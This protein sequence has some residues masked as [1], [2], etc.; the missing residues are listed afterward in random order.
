MESKTPGRLPAIR[1]N[2]AGQV[3][4]V[5]RPPSYFLNAT[6]RPVQ[7]GFVALTGVPLTVS[8]S[9]EF[10]KLAYSS[11]KLHLDPDS[12]EVSKRSVTQQ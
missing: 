12:V 5:I 6:Y 9:V 1:S 8:S 3:R 11:L 7:S 10:A 4:S 2:R